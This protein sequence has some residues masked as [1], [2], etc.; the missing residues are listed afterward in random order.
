MESD[1]CQNYPAASQEIW[2]HTVWRTWLFIAYSDEKWLYYKFSL[3]HSCNRFLKGWENTLFKLRSER[4]KT[5]KLLIDVRV[6]PVLRRFC[7]SVCH[8]LRSCLAP[9]TGLNCLFSPGISPRHE[10]QYRLLWTPEW[11]GLLPTG[12]IKVLVEPFDNGETLDIFSDG[13]WSNI[14][15]CK[16][17]RRWGVVGKALGNPS[18]KLKEERRGWLAREVKLGNEWLGILRSRPL[19]SWKQTN[20][21]TV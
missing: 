8:V 17:Y 4:V 5:C 19:S 6:C 21:Q 15:V 1:Q 11:A 7:T 2:H 16:E 12:D 14:G 13:K 18:T 3:H 10:R 9:V 20:R